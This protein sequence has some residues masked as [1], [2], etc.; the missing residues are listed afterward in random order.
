MSAPNQ[1]DES[2]DEFESAD[3]GEP[4]SL[5]SP[6]IILRRTPSPVPDPIPSPPSNPVQLPVLDIPLPPPSPPK[7]EPVQSVTLPSVS[8]GWGDWNID[9]DPLITV[10]SSKPAGLRPHDSASSLSSSPSKTGGDSVSQAA[11]DEDDQVES[12][13]QQRLQRKK[14]RK[15]PLESPSPK[16]DSR[17]TTRVSRPT[18]RR[19]E[20]AKASP[21]TTASTKHDVKDA[22]HVLDRLAAQSPTRTVC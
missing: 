3:E 7:D 19:D 16:D 9:D 20:E 21:V 18:E 14:F 15:K 4:T 22:H 12:S 2:E 5:P 17:V 11:S 1:R 8:D 6:P 10:E 13:N